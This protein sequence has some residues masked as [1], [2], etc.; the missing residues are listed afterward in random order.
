MSLV[1]NGTSSPNRLHTCWTSGSGKWTSNADYT[2]DVVSVLTKMGFAFTTGNDAPRGGKT[3][4]YVEVQTNLNEARQ[5]TQIDIDVAKAKLEAEQKI[6][7]EEAIKRQAK[8]VD[9]AKANPQHVEWFKA[10]KNENSKTRKAF[11]GAITFKN[12]L[13]VSASELLDAYVKVYGAI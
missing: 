6:K 1:T 7:N 3:G 12:S 9:F 8:A 11:W 4:N 13:G 10:V 5:F 2:S